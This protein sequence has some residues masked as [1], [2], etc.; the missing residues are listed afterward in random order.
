MFLGSKVRPVRGADN[1]TTIYEPIVWT[2]WDPQHLTSLQ[3][4]R[5]YLYQEHDNIETSGM[6]IWTNACWEVLCAISTVT[7]ALLTSSILLAEVGEPP[8]VAQSN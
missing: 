1:L 7:A 3:A 8:D 2:M 6:E 4:S 5:L